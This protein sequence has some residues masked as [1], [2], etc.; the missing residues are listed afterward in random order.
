MSST[1]SSSPQAISYSFAA[2]T[3]ANQQQISTDDP[4]LL[5]LVDYLKDHH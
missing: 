2:A 4:Q 5:A 1:S 3:T